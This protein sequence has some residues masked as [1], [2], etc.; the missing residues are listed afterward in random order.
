ME[1]EIV[2]MKQMRQ[3]Q[4]RGTHKYRQEMKDPVLHTDL[5]SDLQED[6]H[7]N[8]QV[9]LQKALQAYLQ[10]D[11]QTD[12]QVRMDLQPD[13]QAQTG[14]EGTQHSLLVLFS[15]YGF[16]WRETYIYGRNLQARPQPSEWWI[17]SDLQGSTPYT[18]LQG[19][20]PYMDLQGSTPYMDLQGSTL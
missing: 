10:V 12:L 2:E 14:L 6:L 8:L 20:T 5:Q 15:G 1:T 4:D 16:N 17:T 11:L 7:L 13:L 18:D 9:D 19:S 3:S